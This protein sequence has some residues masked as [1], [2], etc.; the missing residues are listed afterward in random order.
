MLCRE[1]CHLVVF[2]ALVLTGV[3]RWVR[4]VLSTWRVTPTVIDDVV[5]LVSELATNAVQHAGTVFEVA[6][7][8]PPTRRSGDTTGPS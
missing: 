3:R 5:L 6:L 4:G 7:T 8:L 2:D 1:G